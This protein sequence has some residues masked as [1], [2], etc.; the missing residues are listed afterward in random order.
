MTF[1][2]TVALTPD[3]YSLT[4]EQ[5]SSPFSALA[6][7]SENLLHS[8]K[9]IVTYSLPQSTLKAGRE[10]CLS[11]SLPL[12]PA[13]DL[14]WS[15]SSP[16]ADTRPAICQTVG[17]TELEVTTSSGNSGLVG[18]EIVRNLQECAQDGSNGQRTHA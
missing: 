10:L 6:A 7:Q 16:E 8:S 12:Q 18:R 2:G 9:S 15:G 14:A 11:L 17:T 5:R 13:R 1:S 4:G 3:N